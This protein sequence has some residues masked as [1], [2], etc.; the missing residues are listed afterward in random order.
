[1]RASQSNEQYINTPSG[2]I[3]LKRFSPVNPQFQDSAQNKVAIILL[4][5]SLGS[6]ALWKQFPEALAVATG[7]DV[8]AY[9][10]LGFGQ[11][12]PRIDLLNDDFVWAEA[13]GGFAAVVEACDL[14]QFIVL[15]HSVGGG[16]ALSVAAAY[17]TQ[18]LAVVSMSAQAKVEQLTL[19]GI[20]AAKQNFKGQKLFQRLAKYHGEKT[21][22]VLDA[23]T[24][25]WLAAHFATWD[26]TTVLNQVHC[27]VQVIHGA[28]DEYATCA[29]P[30]QIAKQ[31]KGAVELCI[32]DD[33]G[34][35]PHQEKTAEVIQLV[36]NFAAELA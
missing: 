28:I 16:M 32:L 2:Q 9:D 4:H 13:N 25:T 6:V 8:I 14:E 17:P 30:E 26:L 3:F 29:Q 5:E 21:Q 10:R 12:S 19:D 33:C 1:M 27:P 15:G 11:S 7:R 34:H 36:Q 23:W 35:F 20:K 22:W 18:C 24:E 31:V